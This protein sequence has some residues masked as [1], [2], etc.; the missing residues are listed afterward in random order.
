MKTPP[1]FPLPP[2]K[3]PIDQT[4]WSVQQ[5][6]SQGGRIRAFVHKDYTLGEHTHD[7]VEVN[8]VLGGSGWHYLSN[9]AFELSPG[10]AFV[11]PPGVPHAYSSDQHLNVFHLL[12]HPY[13]L[14]EHL[15]RL[16]A[17]PGFCLMFSVEPFL[18]AKNG[19][20]HALLLDAEQQQSVSGL[21]DR[22]VM[23]CQLA[24]EGQELLT[25]SLSLALITLLSRWSSQNQN[26]SKTPSIDWQRIQKVLAF[27]N[28]SHVRDLSLAQMAAIA[29]LGERAF[30]RLFAQTTGSSPKTYLAFHRIQIA[31]RLLADPN[32]SITDIGAE[33][34]FYD[35]PHFCRTFT[36]LMG[37]SPAR[38]RQRYV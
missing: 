12:L 14:A 7:F 37:L 23:E 26:L 24:A 5:C 18:R 4:H 6:F 21:A 9:C 19:L 25:E 36:K 2:P 27:M 22:L 34:G 35:A 17:L 20:R 1:D 15:I 32:R 8:I 38:Y 10:H 31:A 13:F 28:H 29:G 30:S 11:I 16:R 3:P 33:I